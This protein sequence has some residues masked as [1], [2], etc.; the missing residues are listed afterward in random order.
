M[1]RVEVKSVNLQSSDIDSAI[2]FQPTNNHQLSVD[3]DATIRTC[4]SALTR[5]FF[6]AA[7]GYANYPNIFFC[8]KSARPSP[9]WSFRV[10]RV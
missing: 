9:I 5:R 6:N 7:N 10:F 1:P 2:T 3:V 8:T 4:T